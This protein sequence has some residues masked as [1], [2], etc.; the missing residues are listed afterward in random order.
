MDPGLKKYLR[1]QD[2]ATRQILALLRRADA[3][4]REELIRLTEVQGPG[5]IV[6]REQLSETRRAINRTMR[7]FYEE[8]GRVVQ[9]GRVEAALAGVDTVYGYTEMLLRTGAS[10]KKIADLK[11]ADKQRA[12]HNLEL[13]AK[14]HSQTNI[15]L[16]RQVWKTHAFTLDM[17]DSR[18][19]IAIARGLSA[20]DFARSVADLVNPNTPGGVRYASMRLARTELN[21]VYHASTIETGDAQPWVQGYYW[22][23]SRSH[24][25]HD[26]CD[27]Y[28][29]HGLYK[30]GKVPAKPHPHCLCYLELEVEDEDTFVK[31]V[32][33]GKYDRLL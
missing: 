18:I 20:R 5:A 13:A 22:R 32:K 25:K 14:R 28:A 8:T 3:Q 27:D 15:P 24:P 23:L 30:K 31:K 12:L 33:A 9:Q 6:R 10:K 1:T 21:N 17:L 7:D 11:A 16:S 29:A 26:I 19:N 2:K 4:T